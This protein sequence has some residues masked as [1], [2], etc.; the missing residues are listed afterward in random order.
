MNTGAHINKDQFSVTRDGMSQAERWF[1]TLVPSYVQIESREIPDHIDFLYHLSKSIHYFNDDDKPDGKWEDFFTSDPSLV[2]I[3]LSR[4]NLTELDNQFVLRKNTLMNARTDEQSVA[5]LR[6]LL[7]YTQELYERMRTARKRFENMPGSPDVDTM[8]YL[9]GN[10]EETGKH[11]YA[12]YRQVAR[13]FPALVSDSLEMGLKDLAPADTDIEL[14]LTAGLSDKENALSALSALGKLFDEILSR[15]SRLCRAAKEFVAERKYL[16]RSYP[17]QT[18]L[19]MTFLELYGYVKKRMNGLTQKHLDYYYQEV[20]GMEPETMQPDLVHLITDLEEQLTHLQI[21]PDDLLM[22]DSGNSDMPVY[23]RPERRQSFSNARIKSLKTVF[24]SSY[25]QISAPSS[26]YKDVREIQVFKAEPPLFSPAAYFKKATEYPSWAVMGED[27]HDVPES[28]RTMYDA[29]PGIAMASPLFFQTEGLRKFTMVMELKST[30]LRGLNEYID[31]YSAARKGMSRETAE[32][33]LFSKAF[34]LLYTAADGWEPVTCFSSKISDSDKRISTLTLK[35]E[36]AAADKAFECY[37]ELVHTASL[38]TK[39]PVLKLLLN[40]QV[41]HYPYSFLHTIQLSRV[42]IHVDVKGFRSVKLQNNVGPLSPMAPFQPFGPQPTIGSFLDIKNS[43]IFNRYLKD[44]TVRIDWLE[45]PL[46]PGGFARYYDGYGRK[47][48]NSAFQVNLSALAGGHYEPEPQVR[49]TFRLFRSNPVTEELYPVTEMNDVNFK[50][51]GFQNNPQL[52]EERLFSEAFFREGAIRFELCAPS[53]AFGHRLFPQIFPEVILNNSK[54]FRKKIPVPNQ[55]YIPLIKTVE[56]DFESVFSEGFKEEQ[57]NEENFQLFHLYPFG[58]RKIFPGGGKKNYWLM[59]RFKYSSNLMIGLENVEANSELSVFFQMEKRGFQHTLYDPDPIVWSYL[60]DDDW[61]PFKASDLISDSTGNFINSGIVHLRLPGRVSLNNTTLPKGLFWIR[62]SSGTRYNIYGRIKAIATN[63]MLATRDISQFSD[64]QMHLL[65]PDKIRGFAK[66]VKG[67]QSVWQLFPSFDGSPSE[68]KENYYV[69]VSERLR[70]KNR[71]VQIRDLAQVILKAFPQILIVKL[72]N[73]KR[74]NF[75]AVPGV[76]LP[77]VLIPRETKEG[78]FLTAQPHVDLSELFR[79]KTFVRS[80]VSPFVK[81]EVGNAVYERVKVMC[82]VLFHSNTEAD[83]I[84]LRRRFVAD[85]NK[86]IAPWLY[87]E[88]AN[89]KIGSAL[90][91]TE[92]LIYLKGLPYVR[93]ISSFSL[94]HFS[95]DSDP[96]LNDIRA[97][98]NDLAVSG[99]DIVESSTP[100]SVLI[101]SPYH[102]VEILK[103]AVPGTPEH[104]GIGNFVVGEEFLVAGNPSPMQKKLEDPEDEEPFGLTI[105]HNI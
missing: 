77:I 87:G 5:A 63:G 34:R 36:L 23:F 80:I 12:F 28:E 70:H 49:Q 35:F 54:K 58:Y 47:L 30:E 89:L 55:P 32:H 20:L 76:D 75:F 43:N 50:K 40:P 101:P 13:F 102:I 95:F 72:F 59:P 26:E 78:A 37:E 14:L 84:A 60:E 31:N 85:I 45:L 68:S 16:D 93:Y 52:S 64:E 92:F 83:S 38:S 88:T 61:V 39:L 79:I 51:I 56:I 65:D 71:P 1:N 27:Q 94:V 90:Y 103:D 6:S 81:V 46:G 105:S 44:F 66:S 48:D 100:T 74:E 82:K 62:A 91:K 96:E 57:A 104:S 2:I 24:L 25:K 19:L 21:G 69:R 9:L 67:I 8:L 15:L 33:K 97:Q 98:V 73:S 42:T 18:G 7:V 17:P 10:H 53:E 41:E 29:E 3:L 11:F 86:Y 99:K 4:A 22:A